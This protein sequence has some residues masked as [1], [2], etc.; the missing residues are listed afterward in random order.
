MLGR[1]C[2]TGSLL[3]MLLARRCSS[4][5]VDVVSSLMEGN[6]TH[7]TGS[8]ANS[9]LAGT[10]QVL[11]LPPSTNDQINQRYGPVRLWADMAAGQFYVTQPCMNPFHF[12]VSLLFCQVSSTFAGNNGLW[13]LILV[14]NFHID[15]SL[16]FQ[17]AL[18]IITMENHHSKTFRN[19]KLRQDSCPKN[20]D[21]RIYARQIQPCCIGRLSTVWA[22]N[23]HWL[24][25]QIY[26]AEK[27]SHE[28]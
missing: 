15:S 2:W 12:K 27:C 20:G 16:G 24:F 19:T 4:S 10:S 13:S 5:V 7:H 17:P 28:K 9:K 3:E 11:I 22:K 14:L 23:G 25:I 1:P 21:D 8:K 18:L 6:F 26:R